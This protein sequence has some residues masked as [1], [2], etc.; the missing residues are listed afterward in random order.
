MLSEFKSFLLRG[1]VVDLAVAVIIAGAVLLIFAFIQFKGWQ[2][3]S[4]ATLYNIVYQD[5]LEISK[6][7][8][9][10]VENLR[11]EDQT[12][13]ANSRG[14]LTGGVGFSCELT[15]SGDKTTTFMAD[16]VLA[17]VFPQASQW[18]MAAECVYIFFFC[19]QLKVLFTSNILLPILDLIISLFF[20]FITQTLKR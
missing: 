20:M 7:L 18:L 5:A 3:S 8:E 19:K 10:D 9:T 4:E 12:N 17:L 6:I 14:N 2:S 11:T 1:N 16:E 15:T 13:E